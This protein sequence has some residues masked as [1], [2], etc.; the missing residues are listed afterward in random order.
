MRLHYREYGRLLPELSS[1][2]LVHGLFGSGTNWHG[3]A[4]RLEARFH[5]IAPDLRNHGSSPHHADMDYPAM[6][7]D[8]L[9][10]L[11]QQGLERVHWVGHSMGA[12]A[13]MWLAL[14]HPQRVQSLVAVDMA[15]IRYTHGFGAFLDALE[16]LPLD[17]LGGRADADTNLAAHFE[18]TALR[19]YLLQNLVKKQ[20]RWCWRI[21]LAALRRNMDQIVGFPPLR[22]DHQFLGNS[23]FVYGG[24]SDYLGPEGVE[25]IRRLFPYARMRLIPEA[26]HWVYSDAPGAFVD[27]LESFLRGG[28]NTPG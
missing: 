19:G 28:R 16:A 15:P 10:L 12:K 21:N 6:A 7:A 26:G 18:S 20:G 24:R 17:R 5:V 2:V 3:I 14:N 25:A 8:L 27:V 22:A 23:L 4:R 11:D 1:L 9:Q 13:A